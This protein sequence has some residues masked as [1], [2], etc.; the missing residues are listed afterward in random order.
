MFQLAVQVSL[1]QGCKATES[2]CGQARRTASLQVLP[3]ST[4]S[5]RTAPFE[6]ANGILLKHTALKLIASSTT[7]ERLCCDR[8]LSIGR[9]S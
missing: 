8:L 7:A 5:S 4:L 6:K 2:P 9:Y 1:C 3:A